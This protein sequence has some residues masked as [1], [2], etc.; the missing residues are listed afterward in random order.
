M[1][2]HTN[3]SALGLRIC[4]L[5]AVGYTATQQQA[6]SANVGRA[7][8]SANHVPTAPAREP[9]HQFTEVTRQETPK[10]LQTKRD[11]PPNTNH[12]LRTRHSSPSPAAVESRQPTATP[13]AH[14]CTKSA[15]YQQPH[16]LTKASRHGGDASGPDCEVLAHQ[17]P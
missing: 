2:Q 7:L 12:H 11:S 8:A 3:R 10:P 4:K 6:E 5:G 1:P 13:E 15:A 16:P 17:D 9:P 14:K